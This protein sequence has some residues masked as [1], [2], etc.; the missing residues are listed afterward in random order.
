[1]TQSNQEKYSH[2]PNEIRQFHD[3]LRFELFSSDP[4]QMRHKFLH[5][6]EFRPHA[7]VLSAPVPIPFDVASD[8]R[9][10]AIANHE[11]EW[12][13]TNRSLQDVVY[14]PEHP[15][16]GVIIIRKGEIVFEA[17]PH[18]S[19]WDRHI[20]MS[21]SKPMTGACIAVLEAQNLIDVADPVEKYIP[22]LC[23]THWQGTSIQDLLDMA[24]GIDALEESPGAMTDPNHPSTIYES[25]LGN[26]GEYSK[27]PSI[28]EVVKSLDRCAPAGSIY[29]YN[30]ANTF[31]LGWIVEQVTNVPYNRF[32]SQEIWSRIGTEKDAFIQVSPHGAQANEGGVSCILRDLARFGQLYTSSGR[33]MFGDI[34]PKDHINAIQTGGRTDIYRLGEKNDSDDA[35][36]FNSRQWD[37][38]WENGDFFKLGW[39]GQGLYVSPSKDVV[40]AFFGTLDENRQKND[41]PDIA[42]KLTLSGALD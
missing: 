19:E 8:E 25:S 23:D 31:V 34:L 37:K 24:S 12:R 22:D 5:F 40:I 39:G 6:T 30:S 42:R 3:P 38:V 36:I 17:Y 28:Y 27:A 11:I 13:S 32:F 29:Q 35:P 20:A 7:V 26:V 21:V 10:A 15:V 18:M 9:R 16:D 4:V 41:L 14:A 1:M 2:K 33:T